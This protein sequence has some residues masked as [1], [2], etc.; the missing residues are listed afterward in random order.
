M[1]DF[2]FTEYIKIAL[3]AGLLGTLSMTIVLYFINRS[4]FA[5]SDMVRAIGSLFTKKYENS[6]IPGIIIHFLFGIIFAGIYGLI[7]DSLNPNGFTAV[8]GYGF[9]LGLF[10]GAAV[11]LL[12]T[13]AVAE[14]HPLEKF[15][16]AGFTVAA[17]HWFAHIV[18]G[19]VVGLIIAEITF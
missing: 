3:I 13:I 1:I 10:Q 16:K 8:I 14:H 6:F 11:G 18:Y 15:Q 17:A 12:L 4:G 7:I 5:N 9:G 19:L 2:S